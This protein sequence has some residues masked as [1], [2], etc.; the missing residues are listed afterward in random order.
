ML[1]L[2]DE[3]HAYIIEAFNSTARYLGLLFYFI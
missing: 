1:S 3:N 2:S